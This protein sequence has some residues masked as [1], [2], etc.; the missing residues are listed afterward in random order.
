M[1]ASLL[2]TKFHIQPVRPDAVR[3]RRLV[4]RLCAGL[5]RKLTL[6][7]APAGFGKSTLVSEWVAHIVGDAHS[8]K[9]RDC[10]VVWLSLD[11]HDN[12]YKRFFMYFIGALQT[13][14]TWN[15]S[16]SAITDE[17][18]AQLERPQQAPAEQILTPLLN[19][20]VALPDRIIF[21]LDDYHYIEDEAIHAALQY[22]IEH[23]PENL[24]LVMATREDPPLPLARLRARNDLTELRAADLRFLVTEVAQFM[25][26]TMHLDLPGDD[27]IALEK[28]TE[29]WVGG[30]Q[31]AGMSLQ[32]A[33][34]ASAAIA[35]FAGSHRHVTDFLLDE[36]LGRQ[37]RSIQTFLLQ[38]SILVELTGLLC[39]AVTQRNDG[40]QTLEVLEQSNLFI[41]PLDDER[42]WYRYHHL[43]G[44]LLRQKLQSEH[45]EQLSTLNQ[46]ASEWFQQ[47]GRTSDAI[48]HALAA[49][50]YDRAAELAEV[51]W[52]EW[53][54]G[55]RSIAWLGW[56]KALP[57]EFIRARPVLSVACAFACLNAGE[58]EEA[59]ARLIDAEH[60]LDPQDPASEKPLSTPTEMIV[61][62]EEQFRALPA[63]HA[64][65]RAYHAQAI[66]DVHGV[67]KYVQ[68]SL[69]LLPEDD[70][71]NRAAA[72]GL[73]GLAYWTSGDI[74]KAHTIFASNIFQNIRDRITGTFVVA[75]MEMTLGRL[76]DAISTCEE[77]L[78]LAAAY[79]EPFPQ[80]TEDVY[81][82]ISELHRE[83]GDL[84]AA[85]QDLESARKLGENVELPDWRHRWCIANARLSESLGDM[86]NALR[87]LDEA[88]RVFVRTPVPAAR[89]IPA[90]RARV[91]LHQGRLADAR[92]WAGERGLAANDDPCYMSE[93]EHITLAHI[94]IDP[95]VEQ[96]E[97]SLRKA[98][99]LLDRLL[100]AAEDGGRIRCVVEIL[101]LQALTFDSQNDATSALKILE[102]ALNIAEPE[103][104]FRIFVDEGPRIARLIYDAARRGISP[105]Y[106][107]R[108]LAAFPEANPTPEANENRQ[109][110][111][112]KNQPKLLDPLSDRE[113][114]VLRLI[115]EGLSNEEVGERLFVSFHTVK[116]HTRSIYAKLD[117]HSRTE[118]LA[119]AGAFGILTP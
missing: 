28:R 25:N 62:D 80:G 85:K 99:G 34:D 64:T 66:G 72:Q 44:D 58:L 106:T 68:T 40:Q 29:G 4:D 82:G 39:D 49:K 18:F 84:T 102:R 104:Y 41:V 67:E 95:K 43:F 20:I 86:D 76:R 59:E 70:H 75:D 47:E 119:K 111:T 79:D 30:L 87:F 61:S 93:F 53:N 65:V 109:S 36:V 12:E 83:L 114:E 69:D 15:D 108:L 35:S 105:E 27:I 117:V 56:L 115:G 22:L 57:A 17:A 8:Q 7:S 52:P 33:E 24:H 77:A 118:A 51:A 88:E 5:D 14:K 97:D 96:K 10:N 113:L 16:D 23:M 103:G 98:M 90:M 71:Y 3:R 48:R 42:R 116:A 74:K 110:T 100:K 6:I 81:T 94:L 37:S 13:A 92:R 32:D 107:N 54:A 26:G 45:P 50:E 1:R 89:P 101:I 73:L 55:T 63:W 19:G 91:W 112:S 78:R 38:T 11:E 9:T 2:N 31:L 21:I 46:Y 60:W